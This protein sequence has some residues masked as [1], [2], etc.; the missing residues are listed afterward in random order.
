MHL[1][2]EDVGLEMLA[3]IGVALADELILGI[4]HQLP[5]LVVE[6]LVRIAVLC[7][8]AHGHG[9]SLLVTTME[10]LDQGL[11]CIPCIKDEIVDADIKGF[12]HIL[13]GRL[14]GAQVQDVAGYN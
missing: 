10:S 4:T 14:E 12:C 6:S 3:E 11:A 7:R 5:C 1:E 13:H 2:P 8:H 9:F